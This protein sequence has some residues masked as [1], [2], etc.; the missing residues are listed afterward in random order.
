[1]ITVS[2][3]FMLNLKSSPELK[4]G[5]KTVEV[6]IDEGTAFGDFLSGLERH[7]GPELAD[8]IYDSQNSALRETAKPIING[9]PIHNL[10]GMDTVLRQG[11]NILF[12]PLITAG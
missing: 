8:E 11:D 12:L 9:S 1:M 7:F 5:K 6:E 4:L 10:A 3:I 2:I